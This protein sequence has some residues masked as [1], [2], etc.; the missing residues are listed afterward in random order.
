MQMADERD[1]FAILGVPHDADDEAVKVAYRR[2]AKEFH[3][4]VSKNGGDRFR[5]V[6]WAYDQLRDEANRSRLAGRNGGSVRPAPIST[7][8][9]SFFQDLDTHGRGRPVAPPRSRR[10]NGTVELEIT[11]EDAF[12]G[13]R[14]HVD[15]E[16]GRCE[17]C[18]GLGRVKVS[19][20]QPCPDC[21]GIGH[22]RAVQ[23]FITV[24]SECPTCNGT[25]T[26][27][28]RACTSCGGEG[29]G[30]GFALDVVLPE[31]CRDGYR[32]TPPGLS[33]VQVVVRIQDHPVFQREI[34][35][36]R[37]RVE[38]PVWAA[39]LGHSITLQGVDLEPVRVEIP[40]GTWHGSEILVADQ[41]MPAFPGRG[42]LIVDVS[43]AMPADKGEMRSLLERMRTIDPAKP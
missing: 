28:Y 35:D 42:L 29:Q 15:R 32:L 14:F 16:G 5:D 17:E 4:D 31:G 2:L 6:R 18:Q 40:P 20:P 21:G 10:T 30:D 43:V 3:P 11:L 7:A 38:I 39:V 25:G 33:G 37:T 8:F 1:P 24:N 27:M 23:G 19:R 36:L 22:T 34:E 12:R 13:G 9:D 41:G 26:S